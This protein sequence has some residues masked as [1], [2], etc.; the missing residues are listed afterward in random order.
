[1]D[2]ILGVSLLSLFCNVNLIHQWELE[3]LFL[4]HLSFP[5][6]LIDIVIPVYES[7]MVFVIGSER[8]LLR[9]RTHISIVNR[10]ESPKKDM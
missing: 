3:L 4:N 1:M 8:T 10:S 5:K 6:E 7:V 2:H 9:G